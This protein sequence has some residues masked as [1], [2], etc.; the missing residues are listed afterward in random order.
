MVVCY[1]SD[2][3]PQR[4]ALSYSLCIIIQGGSK[5]ASALDTDKDV[6]RIRD[7]GQLGEVTW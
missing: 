1:F 3:Q 4:M 2:K 5:Q 6:P 7:S